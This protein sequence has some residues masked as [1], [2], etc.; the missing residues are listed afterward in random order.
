MAVPQAIVCI[1]GDGKQG[2][3]VEADLHSV[4][5][6]TFPVSWK[7]LDGQPNG[8]IQISQPL[9][10]PGVVAWVIAGTA[11]DFNESVRAKIAMLTLG[12]ERKI[13]PAT[14]FVLTDDQEIEDVPYSMNHIQI[15]R[16]S[17]K[18][19]AKLLVAKV[20][21]QPFSALHFHVKAHLD[22]LVGAW[23]EVGPPADEKWDGFMAA[24]THAKVVGFGVGPRGKIPSKSTLLYPMLGIEGS[25]GDLPFNACAARNELTSEISC[26]MRLD[27]APGNVLCLDYPENGQSCE[28][29]GRPPVQLELI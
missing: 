3:S 13:P 14:A 29:P 8:W 27:G 24:V 5:F 25:L 7:E 20:R 21:P 4:G 17:Q 22:P 26:F 18:Y 10:D 6:G 19:A 23:L 1:L 11:E 16:Q 9:D 28:Q 15:Y 2:N 12:L